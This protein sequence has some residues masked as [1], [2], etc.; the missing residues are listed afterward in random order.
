MILFPMFL[1]RTEWGNQENSAF[2]TQ[3]SVQWPSW[4]GGDKA[5]WKYHQADEITVS[6]LVYPV[7]KQQFELC[8]ATFTVR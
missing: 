5:Q 8:Q 4:Q 7:A 6:E 1:I 3:C 2:S